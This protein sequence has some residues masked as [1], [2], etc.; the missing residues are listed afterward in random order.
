[1]PFYSLES[2]LTNHENQLECTAEFIPN[3]LEQLFFVLIVLITAE[4]MSCIH[5]K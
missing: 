5:I 2:F 3:S 4:S 1:M